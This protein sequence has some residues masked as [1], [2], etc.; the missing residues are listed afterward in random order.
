[1]HGGYKQ[2]LCHIG[3]FISYR[4]NIMIPINQSI[5]W[6]WECSTLSSLTL[7]DELLTGKSGNICINWNELYTELQQQ[8]QSS[9]E[10]RP[11]P[12]S[13]AQMILKIKYIYLK[14]YW[15]CWKLEDWQKRKSSCVSMS[16]F[17]IIE[18]MKSRLLIGLG[19]ESLG[20]SVE[21]GRLQLE[22]SLRSSRL[23]TNWLCRTEFT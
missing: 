2:P 19:K 21:R 9:D 6:V 16:L 10:R 11:G 13:S 14:L 8:R 23:V 18:N 22:I 12:G 4:S 15:F 1:M 17:P 7:R 3:V 20:A 5:V